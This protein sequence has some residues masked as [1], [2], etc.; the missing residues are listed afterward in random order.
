MRRLD[1]RFMPGEIDAHETLSRHTAQPDSL[2]RAMQISSVIFRP[3][4]NGVVPDAIQIRESL[5]G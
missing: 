5:S 2:R 4:F 3:G 1:R